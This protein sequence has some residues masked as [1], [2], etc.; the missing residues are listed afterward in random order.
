MKYPIDS[1]WFHVSL[2]QRGKSLRGL[3]RFMALDPSAVSRMLKGE[4]A[5]KADEQDKVAEYL[6]M[7][8][9][10]IAEHRGAGRARHAS[11]GFGE[12]PQTSYLPDE[13]SDAAQAPMH[14]L[15]G[16]MKGTTIVMPGVDLTEPAD[17][18]LLRIYDEDY[19]PQ[20]LAVEDV[21]ADIG[22]S[23]IGKIWALDALGLGAKQI[24]KALD[25]SGSQIEAAFAA[26][27]K[28]RGW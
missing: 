16:S 4:R 10:A 19:D 7:P 3:A 20:Q 27:T 17:P 12:M 22:L 13:A 25:V 2:R 9:S 18:D 5:M 14:P 26:R 8:V 6:D 28:V 11:E 15:F 24:G 21:V 1:E 23:T